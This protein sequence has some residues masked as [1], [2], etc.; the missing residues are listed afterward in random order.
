MAWDDQTV[1]DAMTT[2]GKMF[3]FQNDEHSALTWDGA[4][5]LVIEGKAAFAMGDWAHGEVVK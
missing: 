4:T 3:D 5:A 2:L 1:K